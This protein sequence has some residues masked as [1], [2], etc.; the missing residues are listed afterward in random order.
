[1]I[2]FSFEIKVLTA[3]L[4]CKE[5]DLKDIENFIEKFMKKYGKNIFQNFIEDL[6][7]CVGENHRK[8]VMDQIWYF[9]LCRVIERYI[10]SFKIEYWYGDLCDLKDKFSN[11]LFRIKTSDLKELASEF[12]RHDLEGEILKN[13]IKDLNW[14]LER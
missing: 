2:A 6:L 13:I 12:K 9:L 4:K 10:E 5:T 3:L 8:Y 11:P 14:F 7:H 1:M